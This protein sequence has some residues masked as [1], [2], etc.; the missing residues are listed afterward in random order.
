VAD[1]PQIE[2][3]PTYSADGSHVAYI[4]DGRVTLKD[5]TK[6]NSNPVP[7]T[8]AADKFDNLAWAPIA[9]KNVLA[10]TKIT[11]NDSDLCLAEITK[12]PTIDPQCFVEPDFRAGLTVHWGPN[13]RSITSTGLQNNPPQGQVPGIGIVR[14]KL[15]KDAKPY[16]ADPGDYGKGH[17]ITTTS[18]PS[19]GVI[20][21]AVSPDGKKLALV[22]NFKSS[23]FRLWIADDP[24]DFLLANATLEPIRACKVQWRGDSKELM[25]I[26]SD[27][28]CQEDVGTLAR[29]LVSDLRNPETINTSADDPSYQPFNLGG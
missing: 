15:K 12:D 11:A 17:F 21:A 19:K 27:A 16:S 14:W 1:G 18:T 22:S 23:S 9:D 20:D 13:G 3:D 2:T 29:V 26:Q 6:K 25:I 24:T 4:A 5:I 10:M 28:G 8:S 7:L